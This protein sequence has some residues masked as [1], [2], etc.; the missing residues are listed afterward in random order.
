[1]PC[2]YAAFWADADEYRIVRV[3]SLIAEIVCVYYC[4]ADG[5][6]EM[7]DW[8]RTVNTEYNLSEG[9]DDTPDIERS[10]CVQL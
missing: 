5:R 3:F 1:M 2:P 10:Y 9:H 8:R 4:L 6:R 7:G